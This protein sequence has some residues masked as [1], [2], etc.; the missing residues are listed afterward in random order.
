M[1]SGSA[2][3]PPDVRK[4]FGLPESASSK[5]LGYA[6]LG[7]TPESQNRSTEVQSTS[8]HQAA[9]PHYRYSSLI[10]HHSSLITYYS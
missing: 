10:T 4:A 8:A 5:T 7:R 6:Q 3:L 1:R 2:A 9:E